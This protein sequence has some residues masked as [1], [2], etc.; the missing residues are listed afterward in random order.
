M[1]G[2]FN[3]PPTLAEAEKIAKKAVAV[4]VSLDG[5]IVMQTRD[6]GGNQFHSLVGGS[7]DR[8]DKSLRDA[9]RREIQ[10]ECGLTNED[11]LDI[12]PMHYK[13]V[14][15]AEMTVYYRVKAYKS[16]LRK[17]EHIGDEEYDPV[18][19]NPRSPQFKFGIYRERDTL[20][21]I[22]NAQIDLNLNKGQDVIV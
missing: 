20:E 19:V 17:T 8:G 21:A 16:R 14:T 22:K 11:I 6:A 1:E 18:W 4:I 9:I 15:D 10:E 3:A 2:L 12:Q 5:D 13:G 7:K